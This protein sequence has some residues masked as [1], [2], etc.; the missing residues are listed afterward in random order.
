MKIAI[1]GLG[2]IGGSI[3]LRL[4]EKGYDPDLFDINH[5]LCD[6]LNG[7][8]EEFNGHGYDLVILALY[9][10]VIL[11]IMKNLPKDNLYLDTASV[12]I[13]I[14]NCAFENGIRLIGGHPVAGNEKTGKESWDP[15]MF[16]NRPFAIVDTHIGGIEIVNE[17]VFTLGANPVIVDSEFHDMALARTSHGLYFI[18]KVLKELGGPYESLSGPGYSSMTRL[19]KQNPLLEATFKKY[20]SQNI[21]QFLDDVIKA[22]EK[23]SKELK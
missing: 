20:N 7:R 3:A 14:V 22:L 8:C 23:I 11:K 17:F 13:P 6:E 1:V 16:E 15:K 10:D 12:K 19:S 18:S 5:E 21:S 9:A 4:R 2:Q